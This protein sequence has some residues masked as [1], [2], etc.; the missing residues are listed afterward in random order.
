MSKLIAKL[1]EEIEAES[2]R[3]RAAKLAEIGEHVCRPR[4]VVK[5]SGSWVE[6]ETCGEPMME[7]NVLRMITRDKV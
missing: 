3:E 2:E 6:C 1:L 5:L 7:T 4:R